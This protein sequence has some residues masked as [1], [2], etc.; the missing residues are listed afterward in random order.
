MHWTS[1]SRIENG[2]QSPTWGAVARLATALE[3]GIADLA[4]L[5]AEQDL[6]DH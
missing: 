6:P 2:H 4:R 1:V 3:I 5:A